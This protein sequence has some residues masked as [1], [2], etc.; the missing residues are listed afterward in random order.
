MSSRCLVTL[1]SSLIPA[2]VRKA[3]IHLE[4]KMASVHQ[5]SRVCLNL[6]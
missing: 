3:S 4:H 2:F 1:I 6:G 5:T